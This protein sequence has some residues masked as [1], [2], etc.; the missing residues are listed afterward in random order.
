VSD[1][2]YDPQHIEEKWQAEWA[3][4]RQYSVAED[5]GKPKK[6]VL[7]M[8]PYPSGDIH[9]GH[10]RNYTIGDVVARYFTMRGFEVLHPIGWDAFGLP[11]E[12]AAIKSSSH[13]AKWTYG[14]I[15]TQAAS[16]KRMGFSYDWDR[17]VVS[18]NVDYYRWGQW[19]FLKFWER[20]LVE[21]KSSPVNWCPSCK[22]VLAN[23]QVI[24][25]GVCWRCKSAVEKRELEQ[26]FFKI[27]EYADELLDDLEGLP[28][29]PERV[30]TMQAN[31][32]GRSHGAEVDFTL[33]DASGE[34]TDERITVFTTRPDTLFGCS[35]F[36]LAPE[37]SLVRGLVAGTEYEA[38]VMRVVQS[39]SRET[40][41]ERSMGEREKNGAFTGRYVVNPVNGDKVPV[42][43]CDYVLMEYGTGAVMAVPCG[44]QRDFEFAH[45]FGLPI[46]PV[47]VAADDPLLDELSGVR[48]RAMTAV[49][50][51][52]AY[53]GP[54]VMV[55]S[56]EF[57]GMPGGKDSEG[58]RAVTRWLEERGQGRFAVNY[59][60]RDWLISRQRY[61]GNPIPAV[62][63]PSCGLVA[64]PEEELPVVL[65]DNVDITK[66]ETLADH[67]EFYETTCPKCGGAARRETDTMDTFTCSSWYYLR[68][69]DARNSSAIWD[70][71]KTDYW[72][73]VDQ[74]IGG[75]EH[76][77]LHLLYSRFFT[78]VFRD[79][80]LISF[81]EP[82]TNLLTQG[83][84][85]KD[86]ETMSKSKGNV[87]APEEMIAKYGADT[88]RAYILFMAPPDKDLEWSYEGVEGMFRFLTR[89][90]RLV[91]EI[92][93][94][95][96]G[97]VVSTS[98][99][100]PDSAPAR[101]LH[102][103]MHR[104]I[105]K[106]TRDIEDFGFNTALSAMME[107]V[108][109]AN[110]YRRA[111]PRSERDSSVE[112]AVA[113][114]LTL[115][116]APYVP[117]MS[118]ELWRVVLGRHGSV[119]SVAWPA[120]DAAAA[121]ADEIELPVQ[122][123]GKVRAKVV[124]AAS[125]SHDEI[126]AVAMSAAASWVEGKDVKKVVVVPGKLVSVV[127]AG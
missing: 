22:T 114:S 50:W 85:K 113:E 126:V 64:V 59:R 88:L 4:G 96:G 99:P 118:E 21:R 39:A 91:S 33:C 20:G 115:M 87:V 14:N 7:E 122:V 127:V 40:S 55:Q 95:T 29:W 62:H 97:A 89:A 104:V 75:I 36:L 23:E 47:V 68:Y 45:K 49:P 31:W 61:W 5:T 35:F 38:D 32:I 66:G 121:A 116:L 37:H 1:S 79:M 92:A 106:V 110:D 103:E 65:P 25:D 93:E 9:M 12:N 76:A 74:Y 54:G 72:M 107:L 26:W 3:S 98:A 18:C 46:P 69:C 6:Y 10:V 90:W 2:K 73:P 124:V 53:D 16:F 17:T 94:E 30:K 125:A 11:A 44:D 63:C 43:V 82:F 108:N 27:T 34:P 112:A 8:F 100:A 52:E 77:I 56:G 123:N 70:T 42:W 58:M 105:G 101:A 60:L 81:G 15:E 57:T 80:G 117:H 84:V 111:V 120:F 86:G 83:M 102:R 48:E 119:H 78:K 24:G 71:R 19:I 109:S 41:V 51:A 13:P 67:P 28:G